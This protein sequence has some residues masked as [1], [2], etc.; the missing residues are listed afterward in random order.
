M[1]AGAGIAVEGA[2]VRRRICMPDNRTYD[3]RLKP[4]KYTSNEDDLRY[5]YSLREPAVP[6]H[7]ASRAVAAEEKK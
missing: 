1:A 5:L 7:S 4:P 2:K 6:V 3:M